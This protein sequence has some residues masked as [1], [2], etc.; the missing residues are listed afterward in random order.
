MTVNNDE[1]VHEEKIK[2][3]DLYAKP[4]PDKDDED[5]TEKTESEKG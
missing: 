4:L 3:E 5:T 2:V 1:V